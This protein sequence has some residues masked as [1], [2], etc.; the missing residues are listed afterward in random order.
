MPY[1]CIVAHYNEEIDK[2]F[3]KGQIISDY[4]F[5]QFIYGDIYFEGKFK[6][7]KIKQKSYDTSNPHLTIKCK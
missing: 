7:I 3:E 6:K 2:T 1:K 5:R 4:Y